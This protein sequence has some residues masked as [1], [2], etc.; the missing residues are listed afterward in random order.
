[1]SESKTVVVTI[2][3]APSVMAALTARA[4]QDRQPVRRLAAFMIEDALAREASA[5]DAEVGTLQAGLLAIRDELTESQQRVAKQAKMID[6]LRAGADTHIDPAKAVM[7]GDP[8]MKAADAKPL[9]DAEREY[10]RKVLTGA[11]NPGRGKG[12]T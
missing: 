7:R 1:M 8:E 11:I 6:G 4:A 9:T 12:K 5:D 3:L 10:R 2:R